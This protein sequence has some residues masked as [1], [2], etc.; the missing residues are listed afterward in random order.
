MKRLGLIGGFA[1]LMLFA[2]SGVASARGGGFH[3]GGGAFHGGGG[4][5]HSGPGFRAGSVWHGT[6]VNAG[7]RGGHAAVGGGWH[8]GPPHAGAWRGYGGGYAVTPYGGWAAHPYSAIGIGVRP[9]PRHVWVPGYWGYHGGARVWIGGAWLLPQT[10]W[11]WVAP[12]WQWNGYQWL[13]Q[14]GYYAPPY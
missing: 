1:A 9:S 8:G 6:P 14:E 2:A 5:W 11:I 3:G 12:H 13:W 10:S 4:G 7:W